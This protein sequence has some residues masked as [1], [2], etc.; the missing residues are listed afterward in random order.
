MRSVVMRTNVLRTSVLQPLVLQP[1]LLQT[2]ARHARL[3]GLICAAGIACLLSACAAKVQVEAPKEPITINLNIKIEHEIRV[4]VDK[5]LEDVFS[6]D[7]G[8]F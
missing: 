5:E 2:R 3:A 6:K 1:Q 7:S 4:K 8:L